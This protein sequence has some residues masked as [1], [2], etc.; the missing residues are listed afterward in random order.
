MAGA[1]EIDA[2]SEKEMER[3]LDCDWKLFLDKA[4][5]AYHLSWKEILAHALLQR[6]PKSVQRAHE[7]TGPWRYSKYALRLFLITHHGVREVGAELTFLKMT[8]NI[9][10]RHNFRFDAVSSVRVT[11]DTQ[12]ATSWTSP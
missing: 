5:N 10:E 2:P 9:Q 3:W 1:A 12:A 6:P 4:L 8:L 7:R 11:I